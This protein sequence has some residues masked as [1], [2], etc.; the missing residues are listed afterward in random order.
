MDREW[1]PTFADLIDRLSIH[2]LKEVFICEFKDKYKNEMLMIENDIDSII[3]DKKIKL[4]ANLIRAIIVL[5]QINTHIWYNESKA[6][7]GED[8]DLHLLKLTHGLNGMRQKTLNHILRFIGDISRQDSKTDCLAAEFKDW[9]IS[10]FDR[11][12]K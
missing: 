8:Q 9:E 7:Q 3:D 5:S 11:L 4:S 10:L 12:D 6:R 1:L 2:Q